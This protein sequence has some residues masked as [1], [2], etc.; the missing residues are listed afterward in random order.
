MAGLQK[1][2]P[3]LEE[4]HNKALRCGC[5]FTASKKTLV[6]ASGLIQKHLN[7]KK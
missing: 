1:I 2:N 6:S 7:V 5:N 3:L 4:G